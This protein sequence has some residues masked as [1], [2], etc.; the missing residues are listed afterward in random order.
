MEAG[1]IYSHRV[2]TGLAHGPAP[3]S[4]AL[5]FCFLLTRAWVSCTCP[6]EPGLREEALPAGAPGSPGAAGVSAQGTGRA[7]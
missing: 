1:A 6:G 5:G 7:G 4:D 3:D 2:S